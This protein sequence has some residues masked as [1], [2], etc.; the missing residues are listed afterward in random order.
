MSQMLNLDSLSRQVTPTHKGNCYAFTVQ[1]FIFQVCT[2]A[3]YSTKCGYSYISFMQQYF[4]SYSSDPVLIYLT[5]TDVNVVFSFIIHKHKTIKM[6]SHLLSLCIYKIYMKSLRTVHSILNYAEM[7]YFLGFPA[8]QYI[9]YS[10]N[11]IWRYK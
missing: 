3:I 9:L 10:I 6:E 8:I 1:Y 2:K 11:K 4:S 7:L 5:A